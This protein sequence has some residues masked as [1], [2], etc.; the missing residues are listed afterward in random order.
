MSDYYKG[1]IKVVP[2]DRLCFAV[3]PVT[4]KP[5]GGCCYDP[6]ALTNPDSTPVDTI[7]FAEWLTR[8]MA[9]VW[10]EVERKH[11]AVIARAHGERREERQ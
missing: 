6:Y 7:S 8:R 5:V 11:Q 1:R 3:D 4:L 10:E 2:S 9:L